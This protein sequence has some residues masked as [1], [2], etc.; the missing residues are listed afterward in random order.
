MIAAIAACLQSFRPCGVSFTTLQG[1]NDIQC[2]F[3]H[4]L[5]ST[6]NFQRGSVSFL[7]YTSGKVTDLLPLCALLIYEIFRGT[8]DVVIIGETKW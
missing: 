4:E 1:G 6:R 3:N 8:P 2:D 7:T 5:L